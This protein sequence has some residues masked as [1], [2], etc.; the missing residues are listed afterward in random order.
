[1][2][3]Q[4][5]S[6]PI[7]KRPASLLNIPASGGGQ[8]LELLLFVIIG[9]AVWAVISYN[10]LVRDRNRVL[11]AWSDID[12][13]LRRR[14]DLI[15]KLVEAVKQYASYEAATLK[16]LTEIRGNGKLAPAVADRGR[17]ERQLDSELRE[18][19]ALAESYPDLKADRSFLEL[20][21]NLTEVEKNI[22]YARRYYNGCVRNLNVRIESIP[23]L[24]VAK[25]FN[26]LKAD[27]FEL[28]EN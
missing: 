12:V 22:Q 18:L 23:D 28:E 26:F 5:G 13:Q 21:H 27:Y 17:M 4:K 19:F 25:F 24:F 10:R 7:I 3:L 1:M 6:G 2:P 15:P 11:T 9:I 16:V 14:Y 20:Q 8:I